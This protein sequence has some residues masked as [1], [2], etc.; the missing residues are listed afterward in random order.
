MPN[1]HPIAPATPEEQAR[2]AEY[3]QQ[4]KTNPD[5]QEML[6]RAWRDHKRTSIVGPGIDR[7]ER[8]F[9]EGVD[10]GIRIAL[11]MMTLMEKLMEVPETADSAEEKPPG[12]GW[13][14]TGTTMPATGIKVEVWDPPYVRRAY[15]DA[16]F[17]CWN[18]DDD[19]SGRDLMYHYKED[20][21]WWRSIA[22]TD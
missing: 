4:I 16:H 8:A 6:R 11:G 9:Y 2:L 18:L 13:V 10:Q 22:G 1:H 5:V 15:W 3:A 19:S 12:D 21:R 14:D 7:A 20:V 17:E